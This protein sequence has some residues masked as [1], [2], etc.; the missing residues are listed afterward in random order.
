MGATYTTAD[1]VDSAITT[2]GNLGDKE[3][4]VPYANVKEYVDEK[5]ADVVAG[6]IEGLGN[7]LPRMRSQNLTWRH[8]GRQN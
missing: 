6:S 7:W 5:I 2:V 3:P 8:P 1:D 4:D